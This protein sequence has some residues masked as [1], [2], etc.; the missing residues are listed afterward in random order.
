MRT[1]D[2]LPTHTGKF[3]CGTTE[4]V[5]KL[6]APVSRQRLND[7]VC[8]QQI[9]ATADGTT[10]VVVQSDGP[11]GEVLRHNR[12][13]LPPW[14][15]EAAVL[16]RPGTRIIQVWETGLLFWG[17]PL[18]HGK[19]GV[20]RFVNGKYRL[21]ERLDDLLEIRRS[22][23]SVVIV[24]RRKTD[25]PYVM[26]AITRYG[27]LAMTSDTIIFPLANGKIQVVD[28]IGE[29][30]H[31]YLLGPNGCEDHEKLPVKPGEQPIGIVRIHDLE[32]LC[33]SGE[34]ES[35]FVGIGKHGHR[36]SQEG[37]DVVPGRL[38]CV[39]QSPSGDSMAYLIRE[40]S[41]GL[42]KRTIA[43]N[44]QR[45]YTGSFSMRADDLRWSPSEQQIGA[46]ISPMQPGRFQEIVTGQYRTEIRMGLLLDFL[47][48]DDAKIAAKLVLVDGLYR[49]FV[50][51]AERETV[52]FAWNMCWHNGQIRYNAASHTSVLAIHDTTSPVSSTEH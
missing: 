16:D 23:E 9:A 52:P 24:G 22:G 26:R 46:R 4:R 29:D 2:V 40:V 42:V 17:K 30:F 19:R 10:V 31:R 35:R 50:Y 27:T 49:P 15:F 39:W 28:R 47:V 36:F 41:D 18:G 13:R 25:H 38:E 48:D 14:T 3:F 33:L 21:V 20:Y 45:V 43:L 32:V 8:G 6:P 7:L 44:G 51:D 34:H 1:N 37:M 5:H 11:A 12:V